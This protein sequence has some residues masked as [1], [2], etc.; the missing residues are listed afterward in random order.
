M[1]GSLFAMPSRHLIEMEISLKSTSLQV[2]S[3]ICSGA[4]GIVF[5]WLLATSLWM[6][7]ASDRGLVPGNRQSAYSP[8]WDSMALSLTFNRRKKNTFH[9]TTICSHL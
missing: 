8:F 3:T 9:G 7:V 4:W 2:T 6:A 1:G 5:R